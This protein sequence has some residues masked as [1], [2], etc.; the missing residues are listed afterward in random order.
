MN[1]RRSSCKRGHEKNGAVLNE[2][3]NVNLDCNRIIEQ[4]M[5]LCFSCLGSVRYVVM[6][7]ATVV[8]QLA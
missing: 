7:T 2:E 5:L 8:I 1:K 6:F 3:T 4:Q